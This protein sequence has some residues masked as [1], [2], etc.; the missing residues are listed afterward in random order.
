MEQAYFMQDGFKYLVQDN[1]S[2]SA[3][4]GVECIGV[5]GIMSLYKT[6]A[7]AWAFIGKN[8][9]PH[10]VGITRKV[11]QVIEDYPAKRIEMLV[12]YEFLAGHRWAKM[13]GFKVEAER[14]RY[15]GIYGHDET[16]YAR[17]K[18]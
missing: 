4:D 14:M 9:A 15:S 12:N 2:L 10:M 1:F 18:E 3:W 11:K 8:A 13:L 5:A 7:V 16:L 17:I 6:R